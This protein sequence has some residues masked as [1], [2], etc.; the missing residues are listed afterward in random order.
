MIHA[1]SACS[2]ALAASG[3][4]TL[5]LGVSAR[6]S[7]KWMS[8]R[9]GRAGCGFVPPTSLN[10]KTATP[11]PS[12]CGSTLPQLV[13]FTLRSIAPG[14]EVGFDSL[15]E[16]PQRRA[17]SSRMASTLAKRRA[18]QARHQKRNWPRMAAGRIGQSSSL[19]PGFAPPPN[20][21]VTTSSAR[22]AITTG[23]TIVSLGT[24]IEGCRVIIWLLH[25]SC[26][27]DATTAL[28]PVVSI[29]R[30]GSARP[31]Q[32]PWRVIDEPIRSG[33]KG[34]V[35]GDAFQLLLVERVDQSPGVGEEIVRHERKLG[36]PKGRD[37]APL[38]PFGDHQSARAGFTQ[39]QPEIE[40][41]VLAQLACFL[42]PE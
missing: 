35:V 10:G 29:E 16:E 18:L 37:H 25:T 26:S 17:S 14:P 33:G 15:R 41:A 24:G 7:S 8:L 1:Q 2:A 40:A 39:T 4:L 11:G 6:R 3:W 22:W 19:Y 20:I 28:C 30:K 34:N 27:T 23:A 31:R 13:T 32:S 42:Q 5:V 9:P 38:G 12:T 21:G 36:L